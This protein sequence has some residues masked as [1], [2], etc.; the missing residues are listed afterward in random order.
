MI[1]KKSLMVFT[2]MVIFLSIGASAATN[3]T[4]N[5]S[6][7]N[8]QI[9]Q[10][11]GNVKK[12]VETEYGIPITVNVGNQTVTAP[13]FLYLMT[14]TTQN[15]GNSVNTPVTLKNVTKATTPSENLTSGKIT[16]TEYLSIASKINSYITTNGRLP[17]Y[18]STSIG[19]MSYQSVIYMYSK[20]LNYYGVYK[21]LPS[22]VSVKSW[23]AT[24][25]GP[26]GQLNG[27]TK[28]TTTRLG[29]T[30]YGYVNKLGPFGKGTNKVAMIVGVHPQE[31]QTHIAML[32]AIEALSSSLHNVQIWV[33]QVV[34]TKDV[35]N[36]NL[37]REHGQ[38]L[39]KA[40][41]VPN[42]STAYK[43]VVDTHGNRGN[44]YVN[45]KMVTNSMYAPSNGAKSVGYLNTVL[46]YCN[47]TLKYYQVVD[48]TSPK[49]VTLPIAAN[50]IPAL[51]YEQYLNQANYA[52]VLYINSLEV[53][54]AVN[55]AFG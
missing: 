33:F 20:I 52:K 26:S 23:Y 15:I 19:T 45:G 17:N 44:Y 6:F 4:N 11:A 14:K 50:G 28:Y 46:S 39:A 25:L 22:T 32:N 7:N 12:Y 2:V 1:F 53:V 5:N 34:V 24:T 31:V 43:L 49:Y 42:I 55:A 51:I 47:G 30:S 3:S 41:V 10:S 16:K 37:G 35:S 54:K 29:T 36:Y 27:T 13:Q 40:Y 18:V 21:Y 38:D 9:T 8:S 48:G